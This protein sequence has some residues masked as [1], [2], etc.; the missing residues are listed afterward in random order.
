MELGE[1]TVEIPWM[2]YQLQKYK[3]RVMDVGSAGTDLCEF[4]R[5]KRK[6]V[7]VDKLAF[8][9]APEDE[10]VLTMDIRDVKKEDVGT[11]GVITLISTLE[12]VGLNAYGYK[13]R[14][15][16]PF[17]TQRDTL[18]HCATLLDPGGVMIVT[19][20]FGGG[21]TEDGGWY[22]VYNA[23][24]VDELKAPF[25]VLVEDYFALDRNTWTYNH[26]PREQCHNAK[27]D[28]VRGDF[29]RATNVACLVLG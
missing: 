2:C 26:V 11:F 20:P 14:S 9:K 29:S 24:Q 16:D 28:W 10:A 12:H 25:Q 22:L 18:V 5:Q 15:E 21:V 13:D 19:I 8:P 27:A 1:R 7:R 6:L 3:G 23:Q 4:R 17:A